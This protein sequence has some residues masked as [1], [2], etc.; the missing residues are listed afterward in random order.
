M[1]TCTGSPLL[2]ISPFQLIKYGLILE[3]ASECGEEGR[4]WCLLAK[5]SG[6]FRCLLR[7]SDCF[8]PYLPGIV[9]SNHRQC[10]LS[11]GYFCYYCLESISWS[12]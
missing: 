3:K 9:V 5:V 8:G 6:S 1:I 10:L 2:L 7:N 12:S 4:I 11:R